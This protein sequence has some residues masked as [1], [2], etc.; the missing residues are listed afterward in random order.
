MTLVPIVASM[1][2]HRAATLLPSELRAFA[3][4]LSA[5]VGLLAGLLSGLGHHVAHAPRCATAQGCFAHS[6]STGA[7]TYGWRLAAGLAA[8]LVV[9]LVAGRLA[10]LAVRPHAGAR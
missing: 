3:L 10:S 2:P 7:T 4:R 8:G 1:G 9:G 6:L 5:A